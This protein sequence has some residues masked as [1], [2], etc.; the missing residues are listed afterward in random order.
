MTAVN[1]FIFGNGNLH[2]RFCAITELLEKLV[3]AA[4]TPLSLAQMKRHTGRSGRD[5]SKHCLDLVRNGL[6]I[7]TSD[8]HWTLAGDPADLTL[9]D[10]Y[11]CA[12]ARPEWHSR[13][14]RIDHQP[15][16]VVDLLLMQA[17]LAINQSVHQH[18]RQFSLDRLKPAGIVPF[19]LGRSR[20]HGLNYNGHSDLA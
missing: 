18:L 19:P 13:G 20:S 9:A 7:E 6:V 17:V 11:R 12:T 14:R 10:V 15:N 2:E 1:D 4:P 16:Y 8:G 3:R 5:I